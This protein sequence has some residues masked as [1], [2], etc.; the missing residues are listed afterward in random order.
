MMVHV[1]G[2][3]MSKDNDDLIKFLGALFLGKLI[4]DALKKYRCPRCNY[5]VD[6]NSIFCPNCGQPLDWRGK[7]W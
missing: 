7:Q 5:P 1:F 2:R 3:R 6:G 4:I